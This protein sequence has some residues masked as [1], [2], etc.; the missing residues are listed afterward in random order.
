[1]NIIEQ[2]KVPAIEKEI[3]LQEYAPLAFKTISTR[4]GIKK[5]IKR[6]EIL[7]DGR[8]AKTSDWI[9][10]GQILQLIQ[11]QKSPKK[12][13]KLS[14]KI[15][16]ED[17]FLALIEKPAGFPTNG[18]YF[19]TIENALPFN[20][21]ISSEKDALPYPIPVHRLDNPTSGLL[22]IA[23]TRNAQRA[24]NTAFEERKITKSY[25]AIVEGEIQQEGE[26][27][28]AIDGK[29][30]LTNFRLLKSFQ[31]DERFFSL[32]ELFPKTGRTHQLRKHLSEAAFPIVGD[33]VYG[34]KIDIKGILLTAFSL[35][36]QHPITTEILSFSTALP[37]KF[38]RFLPKNSSP[39][40]EA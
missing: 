27:N 1:M 35:Q 38:R 14:L 17:D 3:R 36:F 21:E 31:K 37:K 33:E 28:N 6:E 29:E 26:F 5:A 23:K 30:S 7:L 9:K 39:E 2:H 40:L 15:V 16:Y 12:I 24:L 11:P 20:L 10:E 25:L 19:K 18:N 13:F 4:S 8:P 32:V 22:L 34:S